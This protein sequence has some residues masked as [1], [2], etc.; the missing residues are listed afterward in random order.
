MKKM[1]T[2]IA[3]FGLAIPVMAQAAEFQ[4]PGT[5]GMGRAGVARTTIKSLCGSVA[6]RSRRIN[7]C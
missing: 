5:L 3:L 6:Q 2:A 4:T 1:M 7:L